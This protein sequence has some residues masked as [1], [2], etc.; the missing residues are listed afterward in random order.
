MCQVF[1]YPI[2]D[3]ASTGHNGLEGGA[4]FMIFGKAIEFRRDCTGG[5]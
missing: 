1:G 3:G 5:I 4:N 2:G